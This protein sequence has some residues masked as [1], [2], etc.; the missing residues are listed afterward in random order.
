MESD[1]LSDSRREPCAFRAAGAAAGTDALPGAAAHPRP[2][3]DWTPPPYRPSPWLPGGH[4][5]T[6]AARLLRDLRNFGTLGSV[7]TEADTDSF[8]VRERLETP[9]GD[10]VDLDHYAASPAESGGRTPTVVVLHGLE[11]CSR[12]GYVLEVCRALAERGIRS[13]ALNFRS[14]SGEPNRLAR[15]YHAGSTDD[16]ALALDVLGRRRPGT[17]LGA[18]GF[19][20]GGNVVLKFLGERGEE[21]RG[22]LGAAVA[23]SVPFDLRLA[24]KRLEERGGRL[25]TW[26][27]LR[28]LRRTCR[29]KAD[30]YPELFDL[31]ALLEARTVREFDNLVTAPLHGFRDAAHYYAECGSGRYLPSVRTPTLVLHSRDDPLVPAAGIPEDAL[32]AN[33][34]IRAVL[35]GE[36]GHV[37][38]VGGRTPR[39]PV[40]WAEET[41]ADFLSWRL[42]PMERSR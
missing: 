14:R 11:G 18:V 35:T 20:L 6:I 40:F 31:E 32:R 16:L 41:A 2:R 21:A 27:F 30:R 4:A 38:F 39:S 22:R 9:D 12:S 19:S 42:N 3:A 36:G 34:W 29:L 25:Y 23:V 17:P 26:F 37:G 15:S 10:F 33:P 7:R 1:E 28:S 24:A 8:Y 5:Q 13:V